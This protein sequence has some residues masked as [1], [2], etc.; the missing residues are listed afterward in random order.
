MASISA[1][2]RTD[3]KNLTLA[4]DL[5]NLEDLI[6]SVKKLEL[7]YQDG[8]DKRTGDE[9]ID[10]YEKLLAYQTDFWNSHITCIDGCNQQFLAMHER[11]ADQEKA[12]NCCKSIWDFCCMAN[13]YQQNISDSWSATDLE[14]RKLTIL[15]AICDVEKF[16]CDKCT[17]GI[18]SE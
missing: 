18:Q 6:N 7:K 2:D 15:L 14:S 11:N 5:Q 3:Q 1:T 4:S 10:N 8:I 17:C 13:L 9:K 16:R 12:C